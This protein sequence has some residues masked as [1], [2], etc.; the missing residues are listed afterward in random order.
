MILVFRM[1]QYALL[2]VG[3]LMPPKVRMINS[4][5]MPSD[6]PPYHFRG[7]KLLLIVRMEIS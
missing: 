2:K 5:I 6:I 4:F 1:Q 3:Y 7:R